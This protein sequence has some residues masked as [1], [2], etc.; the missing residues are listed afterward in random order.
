MSS[1]GEGVP[2]SFGGWGRATRSTASAVS[3]ADEARV[4]ELVAGAPARG[5]LARGLGRSYG[6]A[7]QNAGG[8]VLAPFLPHRPPEIDPVRRTATVSAG[9]PLHRLLAATLPHGLVPPVLPGTAYVTAGGAV[10]ADVHGK[11][12]HVHGSIGRWLESV[13]LVDG[14]GRVRTLSPAQD[15]EAFWATVGGMGLTGVL[16][17][18]SMRLVPVSTTRVRVRTRRLADLDALLACLREDPPATYQVAWVDCL[19]GGRAVLDDGEPAAVDELPARSRS[20]PLAYRPRTLLAA[21]PVPS[22][23]LRPATVRAFNEAWW[24]AAPADRVR[25]VGLS[26][27]FHPLDGVAGWNR[28]YG[29]RGF[30][31]YQL[32]VP[33][34]AERVLRRFVEDLPAAGLAPFLV[35][36]KRFGSAAPGPLSFP[37]PGWTLAA[38]L[39]LGSPAL[40]GALD[41]LD[42]EVAAA[43][44]RVYLAKDARLR[45]DVLAAMYPRLGRW[46]ETRARLDPADRFRSDLARRLGVG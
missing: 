12:H 13:R 25:L 17:E 22:G 39:P 41:R 6:D 46:R 37:A 29:P 7:A 15:P 3:A 32:A 16:T 11:N 44:G 20:R 33:D 8:W 42:A 28:L 21:P 34:G 31:Q 27:F 24:R 38:D 23:P 35:V 5:V 18:V 10:A 40:P 14:C 43:G 9:T 26:R 30:L 36:L 2:R 1:P 4:A 45:P 19:A